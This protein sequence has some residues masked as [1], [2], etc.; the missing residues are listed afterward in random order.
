MPVISQCQV[1]EGNLGNLFQ[2]CAVVSTASNLQA[3]VGSVVADPQ[4]FFLQVAFE[5]FASDVLRQT[6]CRVF[7]PL[8]LAIF[9]HLLDCLR[10]QPQALDVDVSHLSSPLP[11]RY[12]E[13]C[14]RIC[15]QVTCL[16]GSRHPPL[17]AHRADADDF[18]R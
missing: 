16:L 4:A 12:A 5:E 9:E 17:L 14:W 11:L 18:H 8:H 1:Y 13:G 6:V 3:G 10:L 2:C 7:F 15:K